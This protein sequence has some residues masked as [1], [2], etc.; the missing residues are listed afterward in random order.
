MQLRQKIHADSLTR[1]KR[2]LKENKQLTLEDLEEKDMKFFREIKGIDE[3]GN[4]IGEEKAPVDTPEET[5]RK[6]VAKSKK[7]PKK[8]KNRLENENSGEKRKIEEVDPDADTEPSSFDIAIDEGYYEEL[9][10]RQQQREEEEQEADDSNKKTRKTTSD[11]GGQRHFGSQHHHGRDP[12]CATVFLAV[13]RRNQAHL[14]HQN[15]IIDRPDKVEYVGFNISAAL[16]VISRHPRAASTSNLN[17]NDRIRVQTFLE[18]LKGQSMSSI[19]A[20]PLRSRTR[21]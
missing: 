12:G 2:M 1:V 6:K 18:A 8:S 11:G 19:T 20:L 3:E 4:A 16:S 7:S 5:E 21:Q 15:T 13:R 17:Q 14:C 10:K 9:K